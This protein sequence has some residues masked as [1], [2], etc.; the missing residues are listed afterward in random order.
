MRVRTVNKNNRKAIKDTLAKNPPSSDWRFSAST[1]LYTR[2]M[3]AKKQYK[4][5]EDISLTIVFLNH[6][7]RDLVFNYKTWP[8]SEHSYCDLTISSSEGAVDA[9]PVPIEK[10]KIEDYFSEHGHSYDRV[11]KTDSSF[12]FG[13]GSVTTA[14]RG[15]GYK[16]K[17]N[18]HYYPLQPGIYDIAASCGNFFGTT[19]NTN[20]ITV[21]VE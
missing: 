21:E 14:K 4:V 18:F 5:D 9:V 8:K 3:A 1:G 11:V 13:I 12:R 15:Y 17:L 20:S 7:N 6:T 10:S 16:E 2:L 19:I